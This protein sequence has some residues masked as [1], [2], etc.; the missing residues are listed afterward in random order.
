MKIFAFNTVG[1]DTQ[2]AI[3]VDGKQFF[4]TVAFSRHSESFFPNLEAELK[5]L[6]VETSPILF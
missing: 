5:S 4:K 1:P 3:E 2:I 6:L